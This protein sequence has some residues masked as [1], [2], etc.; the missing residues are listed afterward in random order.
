MDKL[1]PSLILESP[2]LRLRK[3]QE[4]DLEPFWAYR[5]DPEVA[6][7]Q[8]WPMPYSHEL[9]AEFIASARQAQ[10]DQT[11]EWY[12]MA[13]ELKAGSQMIGDVAFAIRDSRKQQAELAATLALPFQGQGYA[14]EALRRLLAYLF[15]ERGL[16]RV[17]ASC[18]P[19]NQ[20]VIRL[21]EQ[22]GF[23]REA[24]FVDNYWDRDHWTSEYL[25]AML[26]SE[27]KRAG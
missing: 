10:P 2:R 5:S 4:A 25:Y 23:R 1:E 15:E 24:H 26:E 27:W 20:A 21:M 12:Q 22:F 6:R 11:G 17:Y 8:G 13:I 7:Y 19:Q 9:A 14:S 18:D 16:H 3:F